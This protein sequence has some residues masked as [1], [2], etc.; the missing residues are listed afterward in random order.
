MK[1]FLSVLLVASTLCVAGCG[2]KIT[3]KAA[4]QQKE[5]VQEQIIKEEKRANKEDYSIVA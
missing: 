5:T 1:K 4:R 3:D 2:R